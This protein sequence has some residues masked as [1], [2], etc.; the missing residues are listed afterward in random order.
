MTSSD[1][2]A[3]ARARSALGSR[4]SACERLF[5]DGDELGVGAVGGHAAV[6]DH[7]QRNL[8]ERSRIGGVAGHRGGAQQQLTGLRVSRCR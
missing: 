5:D 1:K 4:P 6:A 3:S 8:G 2:A 7:R